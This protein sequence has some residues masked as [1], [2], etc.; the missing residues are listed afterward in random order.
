MAWETWVQSQVT[1][2]QRLPKWYLMPPCLTL[3][4]IKYG[5]R[6]KWT[7]QGKEHP[8]PLYLGVV[9]IEKEAFGSSSTTV[10]NFTYFILL[11]VL[12]RILETIQQYEKKTLLY[13]TILPSCNH[14]STIVWLHHLDLKRFEKKLDGNYVRMLLA[15]LKQHPT[16]LPSHKPSK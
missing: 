10:G 3:S 4:I 15:V 7:I 2:Y 6:V 13:E 9:A 16:Y 1:S 11:L 5:S 12:D 14:V 8:S